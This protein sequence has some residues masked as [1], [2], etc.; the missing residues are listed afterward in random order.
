MFK[1]MTLVIL[2]DVFLS[3]SFK[4]ATNFADVARTTA[5]TSKFIC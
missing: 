2:F 3:P 4:M 5:G 1:N